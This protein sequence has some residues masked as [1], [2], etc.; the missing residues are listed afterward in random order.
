MNHS[1]TVNI[2]KKEFGI[3]IK[4]AMILKGSWAKQKALWELLFYEA[5]QLVKNPPANSIPE[6]GRSPG[7]GHGNPL[8]YSCLDNFMDRGAWRA[9]VYGV[10]TEQSGTHS[11]LEQ[12]HISHF[13][14]VD[15]GLITGI[16]FILESWKKKK[17]LSGTCFPRDREKWAKVNSCNGCQSFL[18]MTYITSHPPLT[19]VKSHGQAWWQ[20]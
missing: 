5:V 15:F 1:A 12:K 19:L 6:S 3:I 13:C 18:E 20:W 2:I 9:T 8:Q 11:L 7:E 4:I 16:I 14:Y 10:T 17:P